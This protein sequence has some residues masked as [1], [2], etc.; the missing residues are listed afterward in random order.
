MTT[1]ITLTTAARQALQSCAIYPFEAIDVIDVVGGKAIP[2][3]EETLKKL[4]GV[5]FPG[6][7]LSDTVLRVCT[8]YLHQGKTN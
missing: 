7:A 4:E 2:V 8:C 3:N 6:E 5:R 1:R